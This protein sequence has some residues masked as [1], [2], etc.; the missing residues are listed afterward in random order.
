[1]VHQILAYRLMKAQ[2]EGHLELGPDAVCRAHQDGALPALQIEPEQG[3]EAADA[4]Q[5]V[6]VEGFLRQE[7]DALFGPVATGNVDAGVGVCHGMKLGFFK[8]D[9][10]LS[11][12][13]FPAGGGPKP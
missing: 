9:E 6:A 10:G 5:N 13:K 12:S 8:H 3:A 1:V 4:A 2:F 7:L 11:T